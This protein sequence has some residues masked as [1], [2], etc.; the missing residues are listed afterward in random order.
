MVRDQGLG[1]A[2]SEDAAGQEV[3]LLRGRS[4]AGTGQRLP[5]QLSG[6]ERSL[7]LEQFGSF[8]GQ[9]PICSQVE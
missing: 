8:P 9:Q 5:E 6:G 4:G 3:P 2:L 7:S 1:A